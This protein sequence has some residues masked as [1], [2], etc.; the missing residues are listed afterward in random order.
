MKLIV[1]EQNLKKDKSRKKK[2]R[3]KNKL[4]NKCNK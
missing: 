3:I 4:K 2:T 1:E